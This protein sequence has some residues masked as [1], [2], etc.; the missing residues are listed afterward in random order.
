METADRP[1]PSE[2]EVVPQRGRTSRSARQIVAVVAVSVVALLAL[3]GWVLAVGYDVA[4]E[5]GAGAVSC[6]ADVRWTDDAT[7][8][9]AERWFERTCDDAR[10]DRRNTALLL[11]VGVATLACAVSTV[12]SRRLTGEKLGPLR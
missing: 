1:T 12:P 5:P 8:R 9:A 7:G 6:D 11:G 2:S 4:P 10:D 3:A